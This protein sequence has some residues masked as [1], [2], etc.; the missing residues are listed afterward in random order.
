M[1]YSVALKKALA[2]AKPLGEGYSRCELERRIA[3]IS[4]QLKRPMCDA[5]R[6]MLCADR[7]SLRKTIEAL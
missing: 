3:A 6:I 5:E 1:Q 2:E 7:E 4:E